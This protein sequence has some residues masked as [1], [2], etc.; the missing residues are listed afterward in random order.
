M[1]SV[2]PPSKVLVTGA[3]GFLALHIVKQLLEQGY[4][5]RGTVRSASKGEW[6]KIKFSSFGTKFDYSIVEDITKEGAFDDAIKGVDAVL[7]TASPVPDN[8]VGTYETIYVPAVNGTRNLLNSLQSSQTVQRVVYTSSFVAMMKPHAPG[9]TYSEADWN[10]NASKLVNERP[11]KL[12]GI[13]LY[14]AAKTDAERAA[15][16]FYQEHKDNLKWELVTLTPPYIFGP[17]LQNTPNGSANTIWRK[18]FTQKPADQVGQHAGFWIDVRD[19]AF[20]WQDVYDE[21]QSLNIPEIPNDRVEDGDVKDVPNTSKATRILGLTYR[22]LGE[23]V[24]DTIT[25]L[26]ERETQK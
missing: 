3:N 14:L 10:D 8:F 23:S 5:V 25:A 18:A 12:P 24:R 4:S 13:M 11:H 21:L 6:I 16:K 17:I 15:W 9:W 20:K 1:P 19:C 22:S 26:L 7:H 2:L